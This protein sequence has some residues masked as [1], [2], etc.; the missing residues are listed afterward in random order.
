[1]FRFVSDTPCP[2]VSLSPSLGRPVLLV[3]I[4]NHVLG[5]GL[6]TKV[7]LKQRPELDVGFLCRT[8]SINM[9]DVRD[10][11]EY[12]KIRSPSTAAVSATLQRHSKRASDPQV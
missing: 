12:L 7:S 10:L 2:L 3:Q 1:M 6:Q 5:L 11:E 8:Y 4:G 9:D